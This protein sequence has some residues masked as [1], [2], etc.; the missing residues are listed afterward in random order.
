MFLFAKVFLGVAGFG[1]LNQ[2]IVSNTSIILQNKKE[3]K[4]DEMHVQEGEITL[5]LDGKTD[6]QW[7]WNI[8]AYGGYQWDW[9]SFFIRPYIMGGVGF[10]EGTFARYMTKVLQAN[11]LLEGGI[12]YSKVSVG[13]GVGYAAI[14]RKHEQFNRPRGAKGANIIDSKPDFLV[15]QHPVLLL[16]FGYHFNKRGSIVG[17][18]KMNIPVKPVV[19]KPLKYTHSFRNRD[20]SLENM[21]IEDLE[22]DTDVLSHEFL[23]GI[24]VSL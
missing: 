18:Y 12:M 19:T 6:Y 22:I 21:D 1:S 2:Q 10:P 17:F 4:S 9:K 15:H 14:W 23:F 16:H 11:F 24:E 13:L 5:S 3:I 20:G 7:M 8:N